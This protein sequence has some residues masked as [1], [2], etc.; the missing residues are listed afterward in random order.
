[1][2]L[3]VDWPLSRGIFFGRVAMSLNILYA[4]ED[5]TDLLILPFPPPECQDYGCVC[6]GVPVSFNCEYDST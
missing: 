6:T 5:D 2:E 4:A 3:R 1:M